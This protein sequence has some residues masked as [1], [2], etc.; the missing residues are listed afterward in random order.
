MEAQE[1]RPQAVDR[2][3]NLQAVNEEAPGGNLTQEQAELLVTQN[4]GNG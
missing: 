2:S 1:S 3:V 4:E